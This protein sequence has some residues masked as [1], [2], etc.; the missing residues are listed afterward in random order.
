MSASKSCDIC[1]K[2]ATVHISDG[3]GGTLGSQCL[4]CHNRLMAKQTGSVMPD[5]VPERLSITD[6]SGKPRE[7]DVEFIIYANGKSLVAT[8]IGRTKYKADVWGALDDDFDIMLDTLKRRLKK[9]L[10]VKYMR[11]DGRINGEKLVGYIDYDS[12][13]HEYEIIVDGKPYSWGELGRSIPTFEGWK[14]KIEFAGAG[15]ELD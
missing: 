15:A 4:E 11:A 6:R 14:I 3:K 7:F 1:G 2:P 13:R 12:E 9:D 10:S 8:E 5:N